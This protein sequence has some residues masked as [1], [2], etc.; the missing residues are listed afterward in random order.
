MRAGANDTAG[1][2]LSDK[3]GFLLP[4]C[5]EACR[6]LDGMRSSRAERQDNS[7]SDA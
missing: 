6:A 5:A 1:V 3:L 2:A 7:L 4:P